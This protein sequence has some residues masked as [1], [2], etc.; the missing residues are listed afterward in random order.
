MVEYE[1]RSILHAIQQGWPIVTTEAVPSEK[2]RASSLDFLHAPLEALID[3][4]WFSEDGMEAFIRTWSER[5][6]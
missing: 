5:Y 3:E 2:V 1:R 6:Q 4:G